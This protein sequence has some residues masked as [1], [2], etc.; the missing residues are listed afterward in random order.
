MH[1]CAQCTLHVWTSH[2]Q[3]WM[4]CGCI[5][6]GVGEM[7][8]L[9]MHQALHNFGLSFSQKK[10]KEKKKRKKNRV[11]PTLSD[12]E[13]TQGSSLPRLLGCL[14]VNSGERPLPRLPQGK[15]QT[16]KCPRWET[17]LTLKKGS[18]ADHGLGTLF[19][20]VSLALDL[21]GVGAG[22]GF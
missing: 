18:V 14:P 6:V 10:R 17:G 2:I 4:S 1:L 12:V 13:K 22:H 3:A 9:S 11:S 7:C 20:K 5:W 15:A 19:W 8:S 21:F 16:R